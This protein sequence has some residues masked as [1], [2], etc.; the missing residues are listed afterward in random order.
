MSQL[1][2]VAVLVAVQIATGDKHILPAS[3]PVAMVA[4]G[5]VFETVEHWSPPFLYRAVRGYKARH[6]VFSCKM[7][8]CIKEL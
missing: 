3:G 6:D 5:I 4:T 7:G 1:R 2:P 8:L